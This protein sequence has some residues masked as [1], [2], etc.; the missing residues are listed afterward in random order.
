MAADT[1]DQD[2][3]RRAFWEWT[4]K[5]PKKFDERYKYLQQ[6]SEVFHQEI[7]L[8]LELSLNDY[9]KAQTQDLLNPQM[10]DRLNALFKDLHVAPRCPRSHRPA[11][12]TMD[13]P[14]TS[15]KGR[16]GFVSEDEKGQH[17]RTHS[18]RNLPQY[19]LMELTLDRAPQFPSRL[20]RSENQEPHR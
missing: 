4:E 6:I 14:G 12:I 2:L 15:P 19:E 3:W 13:E 10:A 9:L 5:A 11:T 17:Y 1:K 8:C 7:A 18:Q 20:R 16:F